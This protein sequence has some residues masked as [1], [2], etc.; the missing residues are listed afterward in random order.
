MRQSFRI[1]ALG[2]AMAMFSVTAEA[3]TITLRAAT[4]AP[5]TSVY[6]TAIAIPFA[7]HVAKL[8][9]GKKEDRGP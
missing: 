2:A 8:T 7:E 1:A 5:K 3:Q 9:D 6:N 4:I